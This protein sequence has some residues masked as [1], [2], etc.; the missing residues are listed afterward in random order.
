MCF[1]KPRAEQRHLLQRVVKH[2]LIHAVDALQGLDTLND[3]DLACT[4]LCGAAS[5]RPLAQFTSR[6][7]IRAAHWADCDAL[8]WT[9]W[10]PVRA[11][12]ASCARTRAVD[13]IAL[14]MAR[15]VARQVV[16][17]NLERCMAKGDI[18]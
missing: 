15:D 17:R 8:S 3:D 10:G 11:L 5:L 9:N 6:P 14:H 7:E 1:N 2:E 12:R 13:S 18:V 4:G 16:D